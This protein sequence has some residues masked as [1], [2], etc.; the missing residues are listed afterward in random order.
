MKQLKF[1][2]LS[3][4]ILICCGLSLS[5]AQDTG[6]VFPINPGSIE[7]NINSAFYRARYSFELVKDDR[8]TI[9]MD[10]T[11]GNLDP[12]LLLFDPAGE[13]MIANDDKAES[14]NRN[15][16]IE[17]TAA[18]SGIYIVEATRFDQ[19]SGTTSGTYRLTLMLAGAGQNPVT[20]DPLGLPPNFAVPFTP[21]E[22]ESYGTGTLNAI[23]T[24]LYYAF[25][26]RQGDF[27]KITATART[28]DLIP[29]LNILNRDAQVISNT[30]QTKPNEVVTLA[31]VPETGWYLIEVKRQTG[32]GTY[33]MYI[34]RLADRVITPGASVKGELNETT[35]TLSYVFNATINDRVFASLVLDNQVADVKP[36]IAI[37][38]TNQ[39]ELESRTSNTQQA[40]TRTTIPRSG[41]YLIEVSTIGTGFGGTFS[42][43]LNRIP[44]DISKLNIVPATYNERYKDVITNDNPLHYYR[45]SGKA[46]ELWTISMQAAQQMALDPYLILTDENLN[47]LAFSDNVGN[48]NAARITQFSLPVDGSY[49]VIASRAGLVRG[50]TQGEYSLSFTVGQIQLQSGVLTATLNWSGVAD[51]N[52]FV[53]APSGRTISWSNPSLPDGGNLQIDSNTNCETPTSQPVEH[54]YWANNI[55]LES[56]DYTMWVWY[57]N[58]CGVNVDVPFTLS[59]GAFG[60]EILHI[61]STE[62]QV[63][64]LSPKQRYE[65]VVRINDL[66]STVIKAGEFSAPTRQ[67]EASQ[68]GDILI[69]Y[70]ETLTGS[71]N[72]EVYALFYQF[73]GEEGDQ[74]SISVETQTGTLDPIVILRTPEDRNLASNDDINPV[75]RNSYLE[76][77]LENSGQYVISVTRFALRDGTTT[78]A[79]TIKLDKQ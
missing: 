25:G 20:I 79:F 44:S 11:S 32:G 74:I 46:G 14:G 19:E 71:L 24:E 5:L 61:A 37:V 78:G 56:G 51:L 28:G 67:I 50:V 35:P 64:Q 13:L 54:I 31:T 33:D 62:Q 39:Q 9:T 21:I 4:G 23:Q 22:Y 15:A 18:E 34:A 27:V 42:L 49:Y 2:L 57:Q 55:P 70:G 36:R 48:S 65:A 10:N 45:F 16:I 63:I 68:G 73:I 72:N 17:F 41:S 76:Y 7:G 75:S 59:I 29:Q 38:D 69:R 43:N 58:A 60:Q 53:R 8:V 66:S 3:I 47:E 30:T 1:K 77:T 52:L 26:G 40:G 6:D 12:Y